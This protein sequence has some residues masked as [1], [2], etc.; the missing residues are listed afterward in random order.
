[1]IEPQAESPDRGPDVPG[2]RILRRLGQGG[3]ADV[4][5]AVQLSLQRQVALKVLDFERAVSAETAERFE[6]E[7]RT[8][9]RLDHPHIVGI[10]EVGRTRSGLLYYS[11]PFL[12]NGDLSQRDLRDQPLRVL[13]VLRAVCE[14]LKYAHA[15][16][17]V[18]RDVKPENILFDKTDRPLLT[19]FGIALSR[20][21]DHRVTGHGKALGSTG[22][23]S[24]EQSRGHDIDGRADLYSLGVVCYEMLT[25]EMPYY[26]PDA[27]SVAIAHMQDPVPRLPPTKR[28]WQPLIDRAMAKSPD[29]RF[30]SAGEMLLA[31]E[32]IAA[33]LMRPVPRTTEHPIVLGPLLRKRSLYWMLGGAALVGALFLAMPRIV[34]MLPEPGPEAVAPSSTVAPAAPDA[35]PRA[36]DVA[37]L[38][39]LLQEGFTLL[40]QGQLVEPSGANAAAKFLA[41]LKAAPSSAEA[42]AGLDDVIAALA[43]RAVKAIEENRGDDADLI[44][45]QAYAVAEWSGI[46]DYPAFARFEQAF[47]AAVDARLDAAA[48]RFDAKALEGLGAA[49][50]TAAMNHPELEEKRARIG[51]SPQPGA[52][53]RDGGGPLLAFVPASTG[54]AALD[55][56]FAVSVHEVTRGDYAAFAKA[57]KRAAAK[58]RDRGANPLSRMRQRDW[59]DPGFA[60]TNVEPAVCVSADD[61]RAY[62]AWLSKKT[63]RRYRLPTRSEWQYLARATPVAGSACRLGNLLDASAERALSFADVHDCRDEYVR[64][65]PVGRFA[66]GAFGARDLVGNVAEWLEDCA[67]GDCRRR[68]VAGSSFRDGA[69]KPLLGVFESRDADVGAPD[70]GFRVVRE[71]TATDL[72]PPA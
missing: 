5:L 46:P 62:A 55:H 66:P 53:L 40:R 47:V 2:Y 61:A 18:H 21:H 52:R 9:A 10:Y 17:V 59:R 45:Q 15:Q 54:S 48:R 20:E 14:A 24:P 57:T 8:I 64:T 6:R 30:Q 13:E 1:M 23:M 69:K 32:E 41:V 26:G 25:G 19:D 72:P 27:L 42:R 28:L 44:W 29:D 31:L 37:T 12:P 50:D 68:T 65:A 22:Y 70:I 38:D 36:L 43:T 34:R 58:C 71:L 3:M 60:Q 33:D 11:M 51:A 16:G 7:A 35:E 49:F 67:S 4:F 56:F 39:A 63:G